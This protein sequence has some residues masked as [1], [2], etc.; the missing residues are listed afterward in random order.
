M[1]NTEKTQ[2]VVATKSS[3][4]P[5]EEINPI[6]LDKVQ[7][8]YEKNKKML[9]TV[10]SVVLGVVVLYFAYTKLY[11]GPAEEK[12]AKALSYA[13]RSFQMDSLSMAMNGDGRNLGFTKIAKKY[14]GT[15]AGNLAHYYEGICYLKMGDYKNAIKSLKEFDGH[16][17][18][19]GNQAYGA[20]AQ[21][22][23]ENGDNANAIESY[24]K[25]AGD[26]EDVLLTPMYLYQL[27][28]IYQTTG[29]TAEAK[30]AFKRIRDE[31]PKSMQ[32][33]DVDKELARLGELN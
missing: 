8:F 5:E 18:I 29:K 12:A 2:P 26:K 7:G 1:A 28:V 22:Y 32:A 14:S 4:I 21:A 25:A 30:E 23:A 3:N 15:A 17:T 11:K 9:S 10:S 27:G 6:T 13:E 20:L 31:Y 16:G 24:K 19:V 33:R